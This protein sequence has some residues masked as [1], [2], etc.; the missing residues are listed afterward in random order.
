MALRQGYFDGPAE[1]G[2]EIAPSANSALVRAYLNSGGAIP[3]FT[4]ANLTF[5]GAVLT[6]ISNWLPRSL[7]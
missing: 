3:G 1:H 4:R 6:R 2:A 5:S 7:K